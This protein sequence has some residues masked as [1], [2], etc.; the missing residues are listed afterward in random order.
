MEISIHIFQAKERNNGHWQ[1][2]IIV[3]SVFGK[4][5][6][7]KWYTLSFK[8]R[9]KEGDGH[10][11]TKPVVRNVLKWYETAI[12]WAQEPLNHFE[13]KKKSTPYRDWCLQ[14]K[15]KK[16]IDQQGHLPY[17]FFLRQKINSIWEKHGTEQ[18]FFFFIFIFWGHAIPGGHW[19]FSNKKPTPHPRD[20]ESL[21]P[22]TV[23]S[24]N[25]KQRAPIFFTL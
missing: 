17:D 1:L 3:M 9:R 12:I 24:Q 16:K 20:R 23:V 21:N 15:R 25:K 19:R 11:F 22:K 13:R 7:P 4:V 8:R 18:V 2:W 10:Q 6:H 5:Y 14:S